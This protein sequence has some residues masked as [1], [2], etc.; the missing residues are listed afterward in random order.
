LVATFAEL[1]GRDILPLKVFVSHDRG[2]F[3]NGA[4]ESPVALRKPP[5][6]IVHGCLW[7]GANGLGILPN[8][9]AGEDAARPMREVVPLELVEQTR[10]DFGAIGD[11]FHRN[12]PLQSE[13]A[14]IGTEGVSTHTGRIAFARSLP[15]ARY[16]PARE[17]RGDAP[18]CYA[19]FRTELPFRRISFC[20]W[21]QTE[22]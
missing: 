6:E 4:H 7:V 15:T 10:G 13:A 21:W 16:V 5:A 1:L 12:L 14:K 17:K 18:A 2:V 9:G 19:I 8:V 20:T 11:L 22:A 3:A